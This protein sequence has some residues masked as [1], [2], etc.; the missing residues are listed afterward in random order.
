[1]LVRQSYQG[2][3]LYQSK[4]LTPYLKKKSLQFKGALLANPKFEK[5]YEKRLKGNKIK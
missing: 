1:M 4:N 2:L 5:V 3:Y